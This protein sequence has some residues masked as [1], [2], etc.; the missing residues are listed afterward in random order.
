MP[1]N[2]IA[3]ASKWSNQLDKMISEEAVTG[4]LADNVLRAKFVGAKTVLIPDVD[5]VGL[6]DYDRDNGFSR[7]KVTVANT[8]FTLS[9][10]RARSL[11]L[12]REDLDETG[13]AELAGKLLGEF[14]RTQVIPETDAYVLSK[15]S[16]VATDRNHSVNFDDS[17]PVAQL[18]SLISNIQE[19]VGYRGELVA[20]V[21]ATA[22]AALMN[23][24]EI[25][26]YIT[27]SNFKQ[28]EINMQV[29]SINGTAIIPVTADRMKTAFNF[30]AGTTT[31]TGGFTPAED[32]KNIRMLVLPKK[33]ASLV[34]KTETMRIFT[35]ESNQEADAYVFNYRVYY[36]AFVKKSGLDSIYCA[37]AE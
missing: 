34:K 15:L 8:S 16:S 35:P 11:Q 1:I 33:G 14:V 17:A 21:D 20:F 37:V 30:D 13:V 28:G 7:G 5:F 10:D 23:S 6:A 3:T 31:T 19:Q 36:D 27:V 32:A 26:K 25:S 4:F 9:K 22:Y 29:K 18:I 12:D 24:E 2:S